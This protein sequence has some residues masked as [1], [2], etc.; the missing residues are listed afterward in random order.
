MI[1][2]HCEIMLESFKEPVKRRN[3]CWSFRDIR[4]VVMCKAWQIMETEHVPFREAIRRAWDT[5]KKEC[6]EVGAYI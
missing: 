6:A 2:P 1:S 4:A 3:I 5:A